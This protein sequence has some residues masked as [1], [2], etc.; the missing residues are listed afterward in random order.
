MMMYRSSTRG[1]AGVG[2]SASK[3]NLRAW[4][5]ILAVA[6]LAFPLHDSLAESKPSVKVTIVGPGS[7]VAGGAQNGATVNETAVAAK[8]AGTG[9]PLLFSPEWEKVYSSGR[10]GCHL[11]RKRYVWRPCGFGS[12]IVRE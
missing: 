1:K 6:C 5:Q 10:I 12:N 11:G 4:A 2:K 3:R 8:P 7:S 9:P